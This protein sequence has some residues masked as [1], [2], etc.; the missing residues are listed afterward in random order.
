MLLNSASSSAPKTSWILVSLDRLS[1]RSHRTEPRCVWVIQLCRVFADETAACVPK[2]WVRWTEGPRIVRKPIIPCCQSCPWML[3]R[4]Y[5]VPSLTPVL[6]HGAIVA[7]R[8]E[9]CW[10]SN[11]CFPSSIRYGRPSTAHPSCFCLLLLRPQK[12]WYF[13]IVNRAKG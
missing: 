10:G 3:I 7:C 11:F 8:P 1:R 2:K 5:L 4:P 9:V 13:R 12:T 6:S